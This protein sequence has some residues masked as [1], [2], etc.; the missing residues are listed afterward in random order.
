MPYLGQLYNLQGV[1]KSEN[2]PVLNDLDLF[3]LGKVRM[4][5]AAAAK[6]TKNPLRLATIASAKTQ[7]PYVALRG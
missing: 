5:P 4:M 6:T 2:D 1:L 3:D 7:I